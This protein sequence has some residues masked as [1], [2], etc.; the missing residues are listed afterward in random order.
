MNIDLLKDV[1]SI[2]TQT[3]HE[4]RM[5]DYLHTYLTQHGYEHIVDDMGNI[6]ITKGEASVYP[7]LLAHTDTVHAIESDDDIIIRECTKPNAQGES[8]NALD[9][10]RPDGTPTGIGGDC[11]SGIVICLDLL[12]KFDNIKVFFPVSE[13]NGCKGSMFAFDCN[14]D[15]FDDISYAIMFDSPEN[16]T[17]S[18]SL[19]GY[20]LNNDDSAFRLVTEPIIRGFGIDKWEAHPYTDVMIIRER[21][22][23]NCLN[24]AAGYYQYHT[25]REYVIIDDVQNAINLG[26]KLIITLQKSKYADAI[27]TRTPPAYMGR[28]CSVTAF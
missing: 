8:K 20:L 24:L 3:G 1:L 5:V 16:D 12:E 22:G 28:D 10:I 11:K 6:Y 25:D 26:E 19:M 23:V 7:L 14:P 27:L 2:P 13:E 17:L 4:E 15:F 18:Y 9:G 21:T